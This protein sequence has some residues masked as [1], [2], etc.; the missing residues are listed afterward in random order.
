M[1]RLAFCMVVDLLHAADTMHNRIAVAVA[2]C[3]I[4]RQRPGQLFDPVREAGQGAGCGPGGPPHF[5]C[6]AGSAFTT[7]RI[8]ISG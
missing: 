6:V 2:G 5:F 8:I 1:S 3:F 7:V 4:Y